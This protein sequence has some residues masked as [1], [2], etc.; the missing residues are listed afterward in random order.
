MGFNIFGVDKDVIKVYLDE[1]HMVE[2]PYPS[3][4]KRS[5]CIT[6]TKWHAAELVLPVINGEACVMFGVVVN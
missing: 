5:R 6:Q 4:L 1:F 2:H 3:C